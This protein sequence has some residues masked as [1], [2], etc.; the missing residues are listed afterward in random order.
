M[1]ME[2]MVKTAGENSFA[3]ENLISNPKMLVVGCGGAG[4][5]SVDRL[6]RIGVWGAETVAINTDRAHLERVHADKR[7][8]I[9][10]RK[11]RGQGAGGHPEIGEYCA[12]EARE[13]LERILSGAD[14]TFITAGMGGGT[15]TGSAPVVAEV[16]KELGSVV[17]SMVTIP[18]TVEGKD[19]RQK[20]F[21]GL[22]RLKANS[23][24][25]IVLANDKLLSMVPKMPVNQAFS[26]MDQM[27]SE[28]IKDVTEAITQPSLINLDFADLRT[29]TSAGGTSTILYGENSAGDAR[30][31][32]AEA[33]DNPLVDVNYDGATSALIHITSGPELNLRTITE[34][35]SGFT[36]IM[37]ENANV[38][39][40]ARTDPKFAGQLKVMAIMNGVEMNYGCMP[41]VR[42]ETAPIQNA[43]IPIVV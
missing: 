30:T 33:L 14:I 12:E 8:L 41:S 21:I 31:V 43:Y 32:V 34:V 2:N 24:S 38:I 19:R 36:E 40:G 37:D 18:F 13:E 15:G 7:I 3:M 9:G 27:I 17:V 6:Q 20:A 4:N 42:M 1:Y 10:S 28:V 5:N 16:A 35:V 23:D 11:T 29:I 22:D 39:Y 26:V 25:T